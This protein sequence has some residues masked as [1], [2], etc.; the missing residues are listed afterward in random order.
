M[1]PVLHMVY[2]FFLFI[3]I[4]KQNEQTHVEIDL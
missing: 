4:E 3:R 1:W 2:I